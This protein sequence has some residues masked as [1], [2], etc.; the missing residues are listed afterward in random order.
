MKVE[1]DNGLPLSLGQ[2]EHSCL[3]QA[4]IEHDNLTDHGS[5]IPHNAANSPSSHHPA[6]DL[7]PTYD[8]HSVCVISIACLPVC[9]L[10]TCTASRTL[11]IPWPED[12]IPKFALLPFEGLIVL[13]TIQS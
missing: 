6:N 5:W 8:I 1:D 10:S 13:P 9:S 2:T 12:C 3:T 7:T 4:K 11:S